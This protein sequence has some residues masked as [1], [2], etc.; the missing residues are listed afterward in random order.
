MSESSKA[1]ES[2]EYELRLRLQTRPELKELVDTL[3][4]MLVELARA[5]NYARRC[6]WQVPH[7]V[8]TH[9]VVRGLK[10]L[11][12]QIVA[13]LERLQAT[14]EVDPPQEGHM[15]TAERIIEVDPTTGQPVSRFR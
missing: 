14:V 12:A 2:I 10:Q 3:H 13:E 15:E 7:P 11:E 5:R 8:H 1:A 9:H 6:E 4:G